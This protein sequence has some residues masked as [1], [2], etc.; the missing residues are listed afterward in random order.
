MEALSGPELQKTFEFG[1]P[2]ERGFKILPLMGRLADDATTIIKGFFS[3]KRVE[4]TITGTFPV[5][6]LPSTYSLGRLDREPSIMAGLPDPVEGPVLVAGGEKRARTELIE[7]LLYRLL[8]GDRYRRAFVIDL[9]GDYHA[10]REIFGERHTEYRLGWNLHLNV[11]DLPSEAPQGLSAAERAELAAFLLAI[12][13][14]SRD[15]EQYGYHIRTLLEETMTQDEHATLAK[16]LTAMKENPETDMTTMDTRERERIKFWLQAFAMHP[17][18]NFPGGRELLNAAVLERKQVF[19]F[20]FKI[21]DLKTRKLAMYYLLYCLTIWGG[22]DS[23]VVVPQL[24]RILYRHHREEGNKRIQGIIDI[25]FRELEDKMLLIGSTQNL[26]LLDS[27]VYEFARTYIYGWLKNTQDQQILAEHH[28]LTSLGNRLDRVE[29]SLATL[30]QSLS[31]LGKKFILFRHDRPNSPICFCPTPLQELLPD[32]KKAYLRTPTSLAPLKIVEGPRELSPTKYE[33][34]MKTIYHVQEAEGRL[35]EEGLLEEFFE[36]KISSEELRQEFK[37]CLH[38]QDGFLM[39]YLAYEGRAGIFGWGLSRHGKALYQE[40]NQLLSDL[41]EAPAPSDFKEILYEV[42]R[43]RSEMQ[44]QPLDP[45]LLPQEVEAMDQAIGRLLHLTLDLRGEVPW[46]RLQ[47]Y[48]LLLK[49]SETPQSLRERL[50]LCERLWEDLYV[51]MRDQLPPPE[52]DLQEPSTPPD[53]APPL[54]PGWWI[55]LQQLGKTLTMEEGYPEVSLYEVWKQARR[56]ESDRA[57]TQLEAI[58]EELSQQ[59]DASQEGERPG[60]SDY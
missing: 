24:E 54:L 35:V 32:L 59:S 11:L 27:R 28:A 2:P 39:D 7:L 58:F 34:L 60:E 44:K 4:A 36:E 8:H 33:A 19:H 47:E 55:K 46:P 53:E 26:A 52:Q 16:V 31:F 12:S 40:V 21:K 17:E 6:N 23:I 3:L 13:D 22:R 20:S 57:L 37:D 10:L 56:S 43:L 14:P 9:D 18:I 25:I 50:A 45:Y 48:Q 38:G 15:A 1:L 30:K 51:L 49:R 29:E 41:P 42:Q 5:V